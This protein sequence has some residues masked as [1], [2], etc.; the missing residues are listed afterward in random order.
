M[1]L[2]VFMIYFAWNYNTLRGAD[3]SCF[4]WLKRAVGPNFFIGDA[5]MLLAALL[6]GWWSRRPGGLRQAG[7]A[8]GVIAVFAGILYGYQATHAGGLRAPAVVVVDERPYALDDGR[9]FLFFFDPECAHC[10]A[11][12]KDFA[13]Y[14]WKPGIRLLAVATTQPQWGQIFL[15]RTGFP[16][17]LTVSVVPLRGVFKFTDPPYAVALDGGRLQQELRFFDDVEPRKTLKSIGWI[18]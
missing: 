14:H 11:A 4:P 12:A 6:A 16:A 2:T 17:K 7:A 10:N 9:V 15:T 18:E 13:T 3:C 1:L 8:L 5:L